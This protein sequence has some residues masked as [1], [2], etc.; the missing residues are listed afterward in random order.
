MEFTPKKQLM[1]AVPASAVRHNPYIS[2]GKTYMRRFQKNQNGYSSKALAITPARPKAQ[3]HLTSRGERILA[4]SR[5]R[6]CPTKKNITPSVQQNSISLPTK[7]PFSD[8]NGLDSTNI[9]NDVFTDSDE[10]VHS[11][12]KKENKVLP[13]KNKGNLYQSSDDEIFMSY[14]ERKSKPLFEKENVFSTP[15]SN[16]V[17]V[18]SNKRKSF[19]ASKSKLVG[20]ISPE[21]VEVAYGPK[22]VSVEEKENYTP[23]KFYGE[24]SSS[25]KSLLPQFLEESPSSKTMLPHL[26]GFPN[27]G[28]TCYLNSV[29]QSLLGLPTFL[30]DY[31]QIASELGLNQKSLFYGLS[32]VLYNRMKG[33]ASGVKVSLRTIKENLERIDNS[34][35]GFKMQDANEFLTKVLDTIKDEID[36]CYASQSETSSPE[37]HTDCN[38]M[39]DDEN[40]LLNGAMETS[41]IKHLQFPTKAEV[42]FSSDFEDNDLINCVAVLE[43]FEKKAGSVQNTEI[44]GSVEDHMSTRISEKTSESALRNPVKD[45]FEFQLLESYRCLGCHE[46][47]GRKQEYFGLYVNLPD[48]NGQTI[49]DAITTYMDADER[50]LNCDKCGYNKSSVVTTITRLPR[51]LII[52][53]KRYEYKPEQHESIKMSSKVLVNR[54][55]CLDQ[56]LMDDAVGPSQ[57]NPE[58]TSPS[59]ALKPP[60]L[61]VRNLSSELNTCDSKGEEFISSSSNVTEGSALPTPDNEDEELQLVMRRSMEDIQG[62][63]EDD[64]FQQAIRLSLQE[65]GHYVSDVY[66]CDED[67]WFHYDDESVARISESVVFAEGRQ[68]NGYIFFYMH[69]DL[70]Q[71]I[72]NKSKR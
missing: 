67:S 65:M 40:I 44:N 28:N 5:L 35:S 23:S 22:S 61:S 39:I 12:S 10:E 15:K 68:K 38:R 48:D 69:K 16:S 17:K 9:L 1:T 71:Q 36:R 32:Q 45:N 54:W 70:F 46:V 62:G 55:I 7:R 42:G 33:Q 53:L 72:K 43:T 59:K 19:S 57:W 21:K 25:S 49:Q 4:S 63:Q 60:T 6:N 2:G 31:R 30:C 50:D 41:V 27:Y 58:N 3:K 26:I 8:V 34:F 24:S 11:S 20:D 47:E 14:K 13:P 37:S 56:F 64:E 29:L 66:N 52:Q 51:I 18:Y